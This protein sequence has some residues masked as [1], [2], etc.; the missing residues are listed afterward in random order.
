MSPSEVPPG[1]PRYDEMQ[2]RDPAAPHV[3]VP[4]LYGCLICG[5]DR[6]RAEHAEP[7]PTPFVQVVRSSD[8]ERCPIRSMLP[9][10]YVVVNGE[11]RCGCEVDG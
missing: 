4:S 2:R 8:I 10:H 11:V 6:P 5:H 9:R 3:Y 7:A 1:H